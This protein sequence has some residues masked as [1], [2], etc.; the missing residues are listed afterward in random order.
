VTAIDSERYNDD[1]EPL[2]TV[3]RRFGVD[4]LD[5]DVTTAA[6][7]MSMPTAGLTN[8]FT[9]VP[10][11]GPLAIL[12]DA[13]AGRANHVRCAADEWTV[14]SELSLELSPAA[15]H[16]TDDPEDRVIAAAHAVGR[17]GRTSVSLCTLT[18]GADTIGCGTVRSY[19]ISADRMVAERRDSSP[20]GPNT[21]LAEL[22]AVQVQPAD[23]GVAVL[24]QKPNP[25]IY[26][27]IDAVHGGVATAGL[28][29]A[30]SAIMSNGSDHMVTASIRV[31][32]LRPFFASGQSRYVATPLRIGRTSAVADAQAIGED[33]RAALV[34]R[35]TAYR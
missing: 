2:T 20:P 23:D 33:G 18:K 34:A 17:K 12:V 1:L 16:S 15:L 13:A 25:A 19:F 7:V 5:R 11:L 3:E 21:A 31:N 8:P 35:V 14:S 32:F 9:G 27:R 24:M 29:L 22:M 4:I 26:N 28:E 30:A 10:T 6:A